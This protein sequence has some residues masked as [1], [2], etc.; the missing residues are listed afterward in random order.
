MRL[1][2]ILALL[3]VGCTAPNP[4]YN[5]ISLAPAPGPQEP[6]G[7]DAGVIEDL[8][9]LGQDLAQLDDMATR[10]SD[11]AQLGQDLAQPSDMATRPSDLAQLGQDLAQ[12]SDMATRPSDLAQLGDMATRPAVLVAGCY[13][14]FVQDV[15]ATLR[16]TGAFSVV[17][18]IDLAVATPTVQQLLAYEAVLVFSAMNGPK[19]PIALGDNLAA[20]FDA[21][22]RV[23][24]APYANNADIGFPK[25]LQGRFGDPVNGYM[26]TAWSTGELGYDGLGAIAEPQSP[27]LAGVARLSTDAAN[28]STGALINGAIVVASYQNGRPLVVRGVVKGRNRA[29]VNLL[30]VQNKPNNAGLFWTG[31]GAAL[32]RNALLYK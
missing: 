22:G 6:V 20:Y 2:I 14:P 4:D 3:A 1:P 18:G 5:P 25:P 27:L 17:D 28:R 15:Q 7:L 29:D 9:Q 32:L 24:I 26:L 16:S 12:P 23:V 8:A 21:G 31:D 10:P 13:L 30:P 11:L 19:A